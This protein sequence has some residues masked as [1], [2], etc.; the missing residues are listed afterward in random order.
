M[1]KFGVWFVS[2]PNGLD[3]GTPSGKKLVYRDGKEF[4]I[5]HKGVMIPVVDNDWHGF[6]TL[7]N[8]K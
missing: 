1:K 5:K 2:M 8:L 6:K 7:K 4:F 3:I